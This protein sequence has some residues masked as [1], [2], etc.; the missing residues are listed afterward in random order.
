MHSTSH[1]SIGS[2]VVFII[3]K[4][5]GLPFTWLHFVVAWILSIAPDLSGTSDYIKRLYYYFILKKDYNRDP[6][7]HRRDLVHKP[8]L[9]L[10]LILVLSVVNYFFNFLEWGYLLLGVIAIV[11][12]FLMDGFG[13]TEGVEWLWPFD[14]KKYLLFV[15]A[16]IDPREWF[17]YYF[18][19]SFFIT[20]EIVG[21]IASA[22]VLYIS[23]A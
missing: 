3:F 7:E 8:L 1:G 11:L 20:F 14:D 18:S 2:V 23:L 9:W 21:L 6:Y 5:F 4:L 19:N 15:K 22:A 13:E 16:D 17:V 12:H 10:F